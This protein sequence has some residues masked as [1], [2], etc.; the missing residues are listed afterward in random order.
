[1]CICYTA[2]SGDL[3]SAGQLTRPVGLD[4]VWRSGREGFTGSGWSCLPGFLRAPLLDG[5][6]L[7]YQVFGP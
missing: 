5:I 2:A 1:M 7:V 6:E 4:G 3:A